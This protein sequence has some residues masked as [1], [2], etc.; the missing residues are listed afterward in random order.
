MTAHKIELL[1]LNQEDMSI[2]DVKEC[3]ENNRYLIVN[4]ISSVSKTIPDY[5]DDHLLNQGATT[6]KQIDEWFNKNDSNIIEPE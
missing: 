6:K 4:V 3:I 5:D 2:E 1:V